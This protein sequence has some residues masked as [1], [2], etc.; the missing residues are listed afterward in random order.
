MTAEKSF[1]AKVVGVTKRNDEGDRIQDMVVLSE[2][3][4]FE[5][6]ENP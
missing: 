6:I 4:F 2:N 5:I 1:F 3:I